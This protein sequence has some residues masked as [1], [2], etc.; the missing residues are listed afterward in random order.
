[1]TGKPVNL[2][3][4]YSVTLESRSLVPSFWT[5]EDA[6]KKFGLLLALDYKARGDTAQ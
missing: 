3:Q 5:T 1:M 2:P 6:N 4:P